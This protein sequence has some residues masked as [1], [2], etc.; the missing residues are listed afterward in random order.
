MVA[1]MIGQLEVKEIFTGNTWT[2]GESL[3]TVAGGKSTFES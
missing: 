1:V 3:A 2:A